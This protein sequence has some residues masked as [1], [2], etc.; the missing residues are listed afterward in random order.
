MKNNK[1]NNNCPIHSLKYDFFCNKTKI[2]LCDEC[3][4]KIPYF[5]KE[6]EL[7]K[8]IDEYHKKIQNLSTIIQKEKELILNRYEKLKQFLDFL[9]RI[10]KYLLN[11]NYTIYDKYN[12]ENINYIINFEENEECFKKQNYLNYLHLG[13][14]FD[15]EQK[16]ESNTNEGINRTRNIIGKY[17]YIQNW[18]NLKYFKNN[19]FFSHDNN[20]LLFYEYKDYFIRFIY[21]Y[22]TDEPKKTIK[23]NSDNI[24]LINYHKIQILDYNDLE[25]KI[26]IKEEIDNEFYF[27]KDIKVN[28][29]GNIMILQDREISFFKK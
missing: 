16:N 8:T 22:P 15:Y 23:K 24:F 3:K 18:N 2:D 20:N 19:I 27:F 5:N 13:T 28:K 12:Y 4:K 7:Q 1:L 26:F 29:N 21:L 17:D 14:F 6:N 9:L 10:N 11:Y 25:K